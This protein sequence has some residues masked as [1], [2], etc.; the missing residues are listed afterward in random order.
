M[1]VLYI[2]YSIWNIHAKDFVI[3]TRIG[4]LIFNKNDRKKELLIYL[5]KLFFIPS[6]LSLTIQNG[7]VMLEYLLLLFDTGQIG[8][9]YIFSHILYPLII[10]SI[11][12]MN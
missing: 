12:F 8:S 6:M 4:R 1:G 5:L 7:I 11:G 3:D 10:Y 2:P 9:S